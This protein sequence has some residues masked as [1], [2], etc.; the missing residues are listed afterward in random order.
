MGESGS[1]AWLFDEK[2]I[3]TVD[4]V[5]KDPEE[6]ALSVIDAGAEDVHTDQDSLEV[7]TLPEDLE[8]VRRALEEQGLTITSAEISMVPKTSV[9]LD[10][11]T[12][13]Q[14]IRLLD[15]LEDLDDVQKVMS[16]AEFPDEVLAN[17]A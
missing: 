5:G 9:N 11:R 13:T 10:E 17:M 8:P 12:A 16:N 15:R 4:V 1:V 2:G 6:L 3:I 14:T 7:Y